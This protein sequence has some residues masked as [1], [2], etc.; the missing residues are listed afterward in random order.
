MCVFQVRASADLVETE[1]SS[2]MVS[3][4]MRLSEVEL[5]PL[6]LHLCEWKAA[7]ATEDG[8]MGETLGGLD[9]RLSFYKVLNDLSA[10]LKVRAK[11]CFF[12]WFLRMWI[13]FS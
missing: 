7:I 1:A 5:R 12:P 13:R 2:A 4:V 9:R 3:L 10:S 8:S 11:Y 6:F